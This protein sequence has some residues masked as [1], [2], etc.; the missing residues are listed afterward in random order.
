[1][2]CSSRNIAPRKE[3]HCVILEE[4]IFIFIYELGKSSEGEGMRLWI[5][6]F[7]FIFLL[8]KS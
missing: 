4:C 1:M 3:L 8:Q 7:Q 5:D 6:V 2:A